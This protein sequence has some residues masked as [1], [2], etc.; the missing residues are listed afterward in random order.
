MSWLEVFSKENQF[1]YMM[2][3]IMNTTKMYVNGLTILYNV[4]QGG[5]NNDISTIEIRTL[6]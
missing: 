4:H 1:S 2:N 3:R 5:Y 6:E